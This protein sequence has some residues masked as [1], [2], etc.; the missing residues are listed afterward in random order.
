MRYV[1]LLG[2]NTKSLQ[3]HHDC[4]QAGRINANLLTSLRYLLDSRY[5]ALSLNKRCPHR[6]DDRKARAWVSP[7]WEL[8]YLRPIPEPG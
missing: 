2:C 3:T 7:I 5:T 1:K 6:A 8:D 4:Q